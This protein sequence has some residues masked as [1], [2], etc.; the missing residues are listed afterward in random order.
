V[1]LVHLESRDR[2]AL[3]FRMA[4][5]AIGAA[6]IVAAFATPGGTSP[7][8]ISAFLL[9]TVGGAIAY[10]LLTSI[11]RCPSCGVPLTNFR[12]ES[13]DEKRKTFACD[14]CGSVAFLREGFYWQSDV[15]G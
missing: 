10:Y 8:V 11:V 9:V 6:V 1:S 13:D 3:W 5:A 7:W 2:H 15:A 12:I 14:Q 4:G